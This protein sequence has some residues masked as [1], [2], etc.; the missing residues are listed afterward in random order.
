MHSLRSRI[1]TALMVSVACGICF[2]QNSCR[3]TLYKAAEQGDMD[4]VELQL[5]QGHMNTWANGPQNIF[6]LPMCVG[7]VAID[8][9]TLILAAVTGGAYY[10]CLCTDR[11]YLTP[12]FLKTPRDAALDAGQ[13]EIADLLER[14]GMGTMFRKHY[15]GDYNKAP[16]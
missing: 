14:R 15:H 2:S 6:L 7:A 4:M 1:R 16:R 10:H 13:Y 11:P 8:T 9:T 3:S 5:K 12:R